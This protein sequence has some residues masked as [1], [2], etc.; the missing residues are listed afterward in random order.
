MSLFKHSRFLT[1]T[2]L[3][4]FHLETKCHTRL[5]DPEGGRMFIERPYKPFTDPEGGRM[6]TITIYDHLRGRDFFVEN[7]SINM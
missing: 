2:V 6:F 1:D 3:T 7:C 4:I 5:A